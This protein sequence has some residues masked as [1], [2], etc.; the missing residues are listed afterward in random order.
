MDYSNLEKG[1]SFI[2]YSQIF[3]IAAAVIGSSI[4]GIKYF[5]D[6]DLSD[7]AT[8]YSLLI[9]LVNVILILV[10]AVFTVFFGVFG[11]IG[12]CKAAK[13]EGEFKK[14]A[15]CLL[16]SGMLTGVGMF[17]H[18]PND[19]LYII[20]TSSGTV[21]EMFVVIFAVSGMIKVSDICENFDISARGDAMLKV[22]VV[23]YIISA[24][25]NL[26]ICFLELTAHVQ[27][28]SVLFDTG[29]SLLSI[30]RY[31]LYL[32]YLKSCSQMLAEYRAKD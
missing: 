3:V 10:Y 6:V 7:C 4:L 32:R 26:I 18:I 31:V 24:V 13:D 22:I 27:I 8:R 23:T 9:L 12:Y 14:S 20:L 11:M 17:L 16:V 2:R 5:C 25:S 19:L 29:D 21:M 30:A 28:F 15:I 1:I